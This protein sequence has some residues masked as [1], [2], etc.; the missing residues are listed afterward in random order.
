MQITHIFNP[1]PPNILTF[2]PYL[3]SYFTCYYVKSS[4]I[5]SQTKSSISS[6]IKQ[7]YKISDEI[8]SMYREKTLQH[9]GESVL[10]TYR[11]RGLQK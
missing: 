1:A 2:N 3:H 8:I 11:A 5:L 7:C 10:H 6:P 4:G 9:Y